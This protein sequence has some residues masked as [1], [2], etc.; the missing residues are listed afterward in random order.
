MLRTY[1]NDF[2][3]P[4][5]RPLR[6]PE[7]LQP[8][9][10]TLFPEYGV[11]VEPPARRIYSLN[12]VVSALVGKIAEAHDRIAENRAKAGREKCPLAGTCGLTATP[13][14]AG[15]LDGEHELI[16]SCSRRRKG[17][18]DRVRQ[19]ASE[20]ETVVGLSGRRLEHWIKDQ[21]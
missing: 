8:K 13:N 11:T 10:D 7:A 21:K 5:N 15:E 20:V 18:A 17:C 16:I 14:Y 1:M 12:H 2:Y 9:P 19:T 3:R 6:E 4:E